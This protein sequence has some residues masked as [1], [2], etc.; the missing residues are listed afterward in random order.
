MAEKNSIEQQVNKFST[1]LA[2]KDM[3]Y[4]LVE[5][6]SDCCVK[7]RFPGVYNGVEVIWNARIQTLQDKLRSNQKDKSSDKE[8]CSLHQSIMISETVQGY[9]IDIALNLKEIDVAAIKRT[10]IMIRKYKRLHPGLHEYGEAI[11]YKPD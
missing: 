9:S 1:S 11:T 3:Q 2:E 8:A 10:I 7:I 5:R 4:E 6:Q